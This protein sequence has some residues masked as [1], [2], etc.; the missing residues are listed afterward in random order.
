MIDP[1]ALLEDLKRQVRN[2]EADL[3]QTGAVEAYAALREEWQ[4][5]KEAGRTAAAFEQW[6]PERVT[7]V[8]VAWILSTVFVRFCEDN[9]LLEHPFIAGPAPVSTRPANS[10]RRSSPN[11]RARTTTTGSPRHLTPCRCPRPPG[12]CSTR[13]TTRCR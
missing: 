4:E 12:A 13:P 1:P 9:G 11:T 6:L 8:A 7:Q 10:G 3:R 2:L 5:A